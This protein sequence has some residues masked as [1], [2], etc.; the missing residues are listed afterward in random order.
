[1][2]SRACA[3]AMVLLCLSAQAQDQ[4]IR[5]VQP[6]NAMASTAV[7]DIVVDQQGNMLFASHLGLFAYDGQRY[8]SYTQHDGLANSSSNIVERDPSGRIWVVAYS[9]K[10]SIL[11]NNAV[12]EFTAYNRSPYCGQSPTRVFFPAKDR[13]V[14]DQF[15]KGVLLYYRL[16]KNTWTF[17][18]KIQFN[19]KERIPIITAG[20]ELIWFEYAD[21]SESQRFTIRQGSRHTEFPLDAD[22]LSIFRRQHNG[23]AYVSIERWLLVFYPEGIKSRRFDQPLGPAYEGT[24]GSIWLSYKGKGGQELNAKDLSVKGEHF[25]KE[26]WIVDMCQDLE[27]NLWLA[28]S[29]GKL[30]MLPFSPYKKRNVGESAKGPLNSVYGLHDT[31][32][33]AHTNGNISYIVPGQMAEERLLYT[34]SEHPGL[35]PTGGREFEVYQGALYLCSPRNGLFRIDR[36]TLEVEQVLSSLGIWELYLANDQLYLACTE[37]LY[38][39]DGKDVRQ[40]SEHSIRAVTFTPEGQ[41]LL[42]QLDG[43]YELKKG[44]SSKVNW[45]VRTDER[46]TAFASQKNKTVVATFG[47]GLIVKD[48]KTF[49]QIRQK[50]GLPSDFINYLLFNHAGDLVVSTG[51]GIALVSFHTGGKKGFTIRKIAGNECLDR[52]T[53]YIA[54]LDKTLFFSSP[55]G[56]LEVREISREIRGNPLCIKSITLNGKALQGE[57]LTFDYNARNLL[58]IHYRQNSFIPGENSI[59]YYRLGKDQKWIRTSNES[60]LLSDLAPGTYKLELYAI[61]PYTGYRTETI[62]QAIHVIPLLY[63]RTWFQAALILLF[64]VLC[65]LILRFLIRRRETRRKVDLQIQLEFS[66]LEA[67]ALRAQ[68]NPHFIFNS[69]NSIQSFILKNDRDSA[70]KYLGK[71]SAMIREVLEHSQHEA[72]SVADEIR[73]L[74][75]YLDLEK[76]RANDSF[77]YHIEVAPEIFPEKVHI[78]IMLI[79]PLVENAVLHGVLPLEDRQGQ[80]VLHFGLPAPETLEI[81][82]RDNGIGREASRALNARKT[83]YHQSMGMDISL[84]RTTHFNSAEQSSQFEIRDLFDTEGRAAGTEVRIRIKYGHDK[85]SDH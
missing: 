60:L 62:R 1:M 56:L 68:M 38:S 37:G 15:Q 23:I 24:H 58:E 41:I 6:S 74:T 64:L 17:E 52:D 33:L 75:N 72:I 63:Q 2:L 3:C 61:N 73:V 27:G 79:Q 28:L 76:M 67:R 54:E 22:Q 16:K 53:Y 36:K 47:A 45:P 9:G 11:E 20:D 80:I 4:N 49:T 77:T 84:E 32:F 51:N 14:V 57:T 85:S 70:F 78:P 13:V 83:H 81:V 35:V 59:Y 82:L 30:G 21:A 66:R 69:L 18:K 43:L 29:G 12:R 31:L 34:L 48:G 10:I 5:W 25:L 44:K 71:F 39:F 65:F 46:V 19:P 40:I 50:D 42:G 7:D 55:Q 26:D 8:T